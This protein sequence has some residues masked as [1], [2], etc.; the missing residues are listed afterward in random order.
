[1]DHASAHDTP[2]VRRFR[3]E[4]PGIRVRW[5]GKKDPNSNPVEGRVNRPLAAAVAVNRSYRD[6]EVMADAGK[7]FLRRYVFIYG[8]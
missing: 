1:M 7:R 4:H 8:T 2:A 3:R 6:I 5:L